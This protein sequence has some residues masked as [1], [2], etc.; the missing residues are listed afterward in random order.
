MIDG[1]PAPLFEVLDFDEDTFA[2]ALENKWIT[3]NEIS[4]GKRHF[5]ALF[6][7]LRLNLKVQS[8]LVETVHYSR[9]YTSDYAV[10]YSYGVFNHDKFCKRL[11]F[12]SIGSKAFAAL[13]N[14][15]TP[16]DRL[17]KVWNDYQG[18]ITV[19][20]LPK[21]ILGTVMLR[22]PRLP[23]TDDWAIRR[24]T[25]HFLGRTEEMD[26]LAFQEQDG[27]ASACA[28][29][30][31]WISIHMLHALFRIAILPPSTINALARKYARNR[32]TTSN[33]IGLDLHQIC[34]V[35]DEI[36]LFPIWRAFSPSKG[37]L[38]SKTES[39][40]T[41]Q[42]VQIP[43]AKGKDKR[44]IKRMIYAYLK[45]KLPVLVGLKL[46]QGGQH[47]ITMIGFEDSGAKQGSIPESTTFK[48]TI[49]ADTLS[50]LYAHDDQT[51]PFTKV[52]LLDQEGMVAVIRWENQELGTDHYEAQ[53]SNIVV[54]VP[55]EIR[56]PFEDI[57]SQITLVFER[58]FYPML[59]TKERDLFLWDIYLTQENNYKGELLKQSSVYSI[60]DQKRI[61]NSFLPPYIWV[62]RG[63]SESI[64]FIEFIFDAT[65]IP[66]TNK[67]CIE[68]VLLNE[69]FKIYLESIL[70]PH[71]DDK[72]L[73]NQSMFKKVFEKYQAE[74]SN[75]WVL[76]VNLYKP[77]PMEIP[78]RYGE[79]KSII[80][81]GIDNKSFKTLYEKML[82]FCKKNKLNEDY[83]SL[84]IISNDYQNLERKR[85]NGAIL[86]EQYLVQ[87]NQILERLLGL[88]T[89]IEQYKLP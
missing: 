53:V 31:L 25:V 28:T 11:H 45:M 82:Q 51:G 34:G 2:K 65:S 39:S 47:L 33:D 41:H 77:A 35:I 59:D 43:P 83:N 38:T 23:N 3:A 44:F 81:K 27:F 30:A 24:Y 63:Y 58:V 75:L 46:K 29:I 21:A 67:Y 50:T 54:P 57:Y 6:E 85:I 68:V 15:A 84:T 16:L 73:L 42:D 49:Y 80:A 5:K 74:H 78:G 55:R 26:T 37:K 36:G 87:F 12:F 52:K 76:L 66:T 69:D 40:G 71:K 64:P 1:L 48:P 9:S 60:K 10:E 14:N 86:N 61:T 20:P 19:K 13:K 8:I 89:A 32:S 62:V 56:I 7:Y 79:W 70:F 4:R 17:Q 18:Y 88:I 72:D 22:P